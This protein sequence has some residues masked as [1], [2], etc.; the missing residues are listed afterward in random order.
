VSTV[1]RDVAKACGVSPGN[2]ESA[3]TNAKLKGSGSVFKGGTAVSG[4]AWITLQ[5]L[6][7]SAGLEVSIQRGKLQFLEAGKGLFGQAYELSASTG[8]LGSPS[9]DQKGKLKCQT[10]MLQDLFPGRKVVIA[11]ESVSGSFRVTRA[12]YVGDTSGTD[13]QIDIEGDPV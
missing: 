7:A 6:A 5:R 3:I 1:L 8:L 11:A 2:L 9:V 12:R 4:N 13:W 10:L